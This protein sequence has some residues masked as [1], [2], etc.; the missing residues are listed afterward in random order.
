MCQIFSAVIPYS[1]VSD[2]QPVG[3]VLRKIASLR[4]AVLAGRRPW[5]HLHRHPGSVP[6]VS[7]GTGGRE[8]GPGEKGIVLLAPTS[9]Y[10]PLPGNH[11]TGSRHIPPGMWPHG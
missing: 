3:V 4:S 1:L 7:V 2:G 6:T 9:D 5:H 11:Q 8:K 10:A